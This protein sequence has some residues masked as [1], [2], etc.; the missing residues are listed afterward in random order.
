MN[1][2][3]QITRFKALG[4]TAKDV[5]HIAVYV[6]PAV[7]IRDGAIIQT[8]KISIGEANGDYAVDFPTEFIFLSM[9]PAWVF[10]SFDLAGKTWPGLALFPDDGDFAVRFGDAGQRSIVLDD[11]CQCFYGHNYQLVMRNTQTGE[12]IATDPTVHNGD[13]QDHPV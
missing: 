5:R 12:L 11:A 10:E 1:I 4:F 6:E 2:P 8:H 13:R 7:E 3:N 9:D